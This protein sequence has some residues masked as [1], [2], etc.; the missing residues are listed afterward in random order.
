MKRILSILLICILFFVPGTKGQVSSY[1][2]SAFN[3]SYSPISGGTAVPEVQD[4]DA[5]SSSTIPLGFTFVYDG[6]SYN[7]CWVN[8]NGFVTFLGSVTGISASTQRSN[9]L[10]NSNLLTPALYPLWDDLDGFDGTAS[11]QTSGIAPNR[12][13]TFEWK[14]YYWDF[15]ASNI[16][17]SFQV[18]LYE[19]SN[20][21]QFIYKQESGSLESP[22]A[23]IAIAGNASNDYISLSNAG[24][25][26]TAST[27][28]FTTS[29][30]SKP[31]TGQVY[32]FSPPACSGT[33]VGGTT[34]A[35]ANPACYNIN[36]T[37]SV[38]GS[39]LGTGLSYQWQSSPDGTTWTDIGGATSATYTTS[40][41]TSTY[42]R[43]NITC[44]STSSSSSLLVVIKKP[45]VSGSP[46]AV[47][48]NNSST[49][50]ANSPALP[51]TILSE[52]FN[53][54]ANTWTT[55]NNTVD[56]DAGAAAWI[57]EPDS[58][59]YNSTVFQ[60]NDNSQFYMTNSDAAGSSVSSVSTILQSPSFSTVGYSAC[61]L[62][63]Y[64][65]F[66]FNASE[67][68]IVQV[69]TDGSSWNTLATY[70][71][72][73]EGTATSFN[74]VTIDLTPY[75][76]NP[77]VYI[78][79]KYDSG[80]DWYWAIDNILITGT[81]ITPNYAWTAL[82][83]A[84]AGLPVGAGTLSAGN[85]NISITPTV[86]G[87]FVYTVNTNNSCLAPVSITINSIL[88]TPVVS[89]T[90]KSQTIS[91][92][93]NYYIS[94]PCGL[95]A[96]VISQGAS[97]VTGTVNVCARVEPTT[98][99]YNT[100][101]PYLMRHFDIEP[102]TYTSSTTARITL[103]VLQS[104][105]DNYNA[106]DGGYPDLPSGPADASGIANLK[107]T[108]Y[109][110][111]WGSQPKPGYYPAGGA[112]LID[113]ADADIV[114]N[115]ASS[116][117]EISFNV[118][119]FSGFFIHTTIFGAPLAESLLS[120][121]GRRVG[122]ANILKWTIAQ[123]QNIRGYAI[124]RSY[125]GLNFSSVAFEN[126]K[127]P[128]GNSQSALQYSFTDNNFNG[129]IQ[130][131]RLKQ[132][133]NDGRISM[134]PVISIKENSS[135]LTLDGLFPNPADDIVNIALRSPTKTNIDIEIVDLR[136][137]V[138]IQKNISVEPGNNIIPVSV[139]KLAAGT[140]LVRINSPYSGT[141]S[142]KF[143]KE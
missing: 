17:I 4:D 115:A 119:G 116:C 35:S 133:A 136:G 83:A 105:F 85:S 132:T 18:K 14:S 40:I 81:V 55:I 38:N 65:H 71:G 107:V 125:D 96:D 102:T 112:V 58:Y 57:L 41:T 126:S 129:S 9:N 42:F 36:F 7:N 22:S 103:Y 124:E 16:G 138:N 69:S 43:R 131:Y 82:P 89:T 11:Y 97:P 140:Y 93:N 26:P 20:V 28:S 70:Q 31:A 62:Q 84:G 120:F 123:E 139:E 74:L 51:A 39:T 137:R 56:G 127:A 110:G 113:P 142:L 54:A 78:R 101:E 130:Y 29:I 34:T 109:H 12:V 79:Y 114:W 23:S 75:V 100:S 46:L 61:A 73:D 104:E 19:T 52:N 98:L 60:S 47:C 88:G 72:A 118:T 13:F 59:D 91:A 87:T 5:F 8:S 135:I 68:A 24:S 33:P 106:N 53:A 90:C 10:T 21:I 1:L 143:V 67:T 63:F 92:G 94:A 108:Q 86:I 50:T 117:W 2:F 111:V 134:S 80:W 128:G 121:S 44:A 15:I 66:H 141:L 32:Q 30:S 77:T 45:S 99:Y 76:N 95:L 3:G 49:L 64:H 25:S 48:V 27:T 37:L 122:S 6:N